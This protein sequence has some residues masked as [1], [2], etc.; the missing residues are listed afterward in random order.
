MS[1]TYGHDELL[2]PPGAKHVA[3]YDENGKLLK[4][5][6]T[7]PA[8]QSHVV[9]PNNASAPVTVS[10]ASGYA[11]GSRVFIEPTASAVTNTVTITPKGSF[12]D[13]EGAA[14]DQCVLNA[15]GS[16]AICDIV[17][18]VTVLSAYKGADLTT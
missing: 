2:V 8:P 3:T 14:V 5:E 18:G 9:K 4:M 17:G 16:F 7:D 11:T 1:Y 10:L 15:A 13:P 12:V 6:G